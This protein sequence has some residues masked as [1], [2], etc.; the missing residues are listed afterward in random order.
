M[1]F[2][3]IIGY[4]TLEKSKSEELKT[5]HTFDSDKNTLIQNCHNCSAMLTQEWL[6]VAI[7]SRFSYYLS[8]KIV[9]DWTVSA[10]E[11]FL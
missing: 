3:G 8:H 10:P 7:I 5:G 2:W 4:I 9:A 6:F 11:R 1:I